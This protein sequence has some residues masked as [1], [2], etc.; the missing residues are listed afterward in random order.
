M[1]FIFCELHT[2][3]TSVV[4]FN[5]FILIN[6]PQGLV[7]E[8]S[9]SHPNPCRRSLKMSSKLWLDLETY[10][11]VPIKNGTY[12]YTANCEILLFGYALDGDEPSVWD[13]TA[14]TEMP[15]DLD[16]YLRDSS[17]EL[18]AHNSM[19]DRNVL[20][21]RLPDYGNYDVSVPRWRD[22]MIQAYCHSLPGGLDLLGE[23]LK[24]PQDL[25]KL[26]DG[27]KLIHLFCKPLPTNRKLRRATR[28]THP[29]EWE[30][31]K[32]YL[33]NDITAMREC[34]KHMPTWNYPDGGELAMWHLDQKINDR[35]FHVDLELVKS[36]IETTASTKNYLKRKTQ[37][38]TNGALESTTK[39]DK[40]MAYILEEYGILLNDLTKSTLVNSVSD[41]RLPNELRE[42]LRIRLQASSASTSKYTALLKATN[43]D[44]RCRGTIQFAGASRT[45][46][47]AGRTFQPQNLPSRGLL[48]E[49]EI[50]FGI[51]AIKGGY[52]LE[53]FP[54]VMKLLVSTVRGVLDAPA[55]R[56][57]VIA[58]LSN[59]EGRIIAWLAGET[60]KLDAFREFDNGTGHDLY[61][62]AYTKAF[63]VDVESVSK[64]QRQI[65][66]VME[67]MLGY[68][69]GVGAFVTGALGYGF[70]LE[71]LSE[72]IWDTLPEAKINEAKK[73]LAWNIK[74]KRS[75][76][77]LSEKA[78]TTCDTLKRLW[79]ESNANISA[80]WSVLAEAVRYAIKN[81]GGTVSAGHLI[82]IRRDGNWLKIRLPS[83]RTMCYPS[84]MVG[85]NGNISYLGIN[86]YNRKWGRIGTHGGKLLENITQAIA[87]DVL[88]A[89][90]QRAEDEGFEIVLHVH[91]E[92]VTESCD[93]K[94]LTAEK[95]A[96]IMTTRIDW[97]DGLPLAAAGFES[98][99]YRK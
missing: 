55:G 8:T 96:H 97:A 53:F 15:A 84:P 2:Y 19:F 9:L 10:S 83:R 1:E 31:F 87:K 20:R 43:E 52:T 86:Q 82:K 27:Q 24:L 85:D 71:E 62:L 18:W 17:V 38:D 59:I 28:L 49:H 72:K 65:G 6:A 90:Q 54:D 30:R 12:V 37:I 13:V 25:K 46:R 88:Y 80:Y 5:I 94:E 63:K 32:E 34:H 75:T 50:E 39:R 70:D 66:K 89:T 57:L 79:R 51:D 44:S 78:F 47:A 73:L 48:G 33:V 74:N 91:D 41:E 76:Y 56:K 95:L 11:E 14:N 4:I 77:G 23:V 58:D 98:Y 7:H 45:G 42:L 69:G 21:S 92:L 67:L 93:K 26:K 81:P 61:N 60:W 35:G 22:T 68:E 36:C 64:S 3:H 40:M 99:R 16:D 29:A